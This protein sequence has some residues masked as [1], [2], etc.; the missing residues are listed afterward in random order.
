MSKGSKRRPELVPGSFAKNYPFHEPVPRRQFDDE[1]ICESCP[2]PFDA[3]DNDGQCMAILKP[4]RWNFEQDQY[5]ECQ[6]WTRIS[7]V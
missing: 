5:C 4:D 6:G 2:H 1:T 7:N 3:H